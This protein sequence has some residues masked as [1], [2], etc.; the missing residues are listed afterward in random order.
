[1]RHVRRLGS[2]IALEMLPLPAC[3][4]MQQQTEAAPT[5]SPRSL[6]ARKLAD[7]A[8]PDNRALRTT[9]KVRLFSF[10]SCKAKTMDSRRAGASACSSCCALVGTGLETVFFLWLVCRCG[11]SCPV[12]PS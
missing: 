5:S 9:R 1:V 10:P 7:N 4:P 12:N 3:L 8:P 11:G 2:L 6:A